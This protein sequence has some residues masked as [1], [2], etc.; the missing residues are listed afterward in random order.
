M[1]VNAHFLLIL[2][3]ATQVYSYEELLISHENTVNQG[4]EVVIKYFS[5]SDASCTYALSFTRIGEDPQALPAHIILRKEKV[6]ESLHLLLTIRSA[7]STD[8]GLY[9]CNF[10]CNKSHVTQDYNLKVIYPPLKV[11]C[12]WVGG[13]DLHFNTSGHPNHT[14][15][16]CAPAFTGFPEG[17]VLCYSRTDKAIT[18]YLAVYFAGE[19]ALFLIKSVSE[20]SCCSVSE[21]FPKNWQSCSDFVY[22]FSSPEITTSPAPTST[23]NSSTTIICETN[24][25]QNN[26]HLLFLLFIPACGVI[27]AA[28][29]IWKRRRADNTSY[30]PASTNENQMNS[31]D[32]AL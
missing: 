31:A 28:Y 1:M 8:A 25:E 6:F 19:T 9:T 23:V 26:L 4:E 7:Q 2:F 22:T 29:F 16:R 21:K 3:I 27:I 14:A 15:L 5:P 20:V 30:Q 18:A 24:T 10:F 11:N 32:T 17:N 13:K 12:S